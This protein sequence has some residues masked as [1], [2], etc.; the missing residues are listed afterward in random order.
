M[1]DGGGEWWLLGVVVPQTLEVL[2]S[3]TPVLCYQGRAGELSEL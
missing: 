3:R 2:W 1:E